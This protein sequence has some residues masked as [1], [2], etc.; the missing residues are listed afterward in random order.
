[1]DIYFKAVTNELIK[2]IEAFFKLR[3][4]ADRTITYIKRIRSSEP[5]RRVRSNGKNVIGTYPSKKMGLSIQFE[6]KTLELPAIFEKEHSRSVLEY[7]DQPPSFK[8]SYRIK[9]KN[10][11]HLYTAD[12]FVISDDWIGWEEW[13]TEDEII[14]LSIDYPERYQLDENGIWRCP[15]AEKHAGNYGLSFKVKI[16][17]DLNMNYVRNIKFLEDYLLK[18]NLS[19]AKEDKEYICNLI[20]ENP[21]ITIREFLE[22][23]V[24]LQVDNL[25]ISFILGN[26]YMDIENE[27]IPELSA[28]LYIS[29]EYKKALSNIILSTSIPSSKIN[30]F[31]KIN[32]GEKIIWDGVTWIILNVGNTSIILINDEK[33]TIDVPVATFEYLLKEGKIKGISKE[34]YDDEELEIIKKASPLELVKANEKFGLLEPYLNGGGYKGNEPVTERTIQNWMRKYREAERK[35]GYGYVGLLSQEYKK[36]NRNKRISDGVQLLME[37]HIREKYENIKQSNMKKVYLQFCQACID[38]GYDPPSYYT[39]TKNVKKTPCYDRVKK[40]KGRKAAYAIG[41]FIYELRS[42]TPRHGDRIFEICHLDHTELDIE[43]RC[44]VTGKN[45]GRPWATFLVDA[46]SRRLLAI[47]ISYDPPSYRSCM[48]VLRECVKRYSR[49]PSAIV[50]DGGKEFESV[51]FETL[52]TRNRCVKFRRPGAK[53]RFGNVVERLFGTTNEMFINNLTGNT[54]IMK[55]VRQVVKEIN[56]KT[57]SIWN[58]EDFV[59]LLNNWAYEI[60]DQTEHTGLGVSPRDMYERSIKTSGA[61]EVTRV[62]YDETFKILTLPTTKKGEAKVVPG[63]GVKINRIYYWAS[64]FRNGLLENR[65]VFVRYDPFN[66]GIAYAFINNKWVELQSEKFNLFKN[67]S[68][69]EVNIAFEELKRRAML[70]EKK[71]SVTIKMLSDFLNSIE[72]EELLL[73]QQLK[74]R[75]MRNLYVIEG[76]KVN[77]EKFEHEPKIEEMTEKENIR[78][79]V[80]NQGEESCQRY[81]NDIDTLKIEFESYEG[82]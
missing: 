78:L 64:V 4:L 42:E 22:K 38:E 26:F 51:Y 68:E 2:D 28:R 3:G 1:M 67:R 74:D 31:F 36:G 77:S 23:S 48:M 41:E 43:L 58:L 34:D 33:E 14:K 62:I 9:E 20:S 79:V 45:L 6:S 76:G 63:Y 66:M 37:T 72:S 18:G 69:K 82:L 15:P 80:N 17:K 52:L 46:F 8:I 44:S 75:A 39:F 13:K 53:A 30:V 60:Y 71:Q 35:Y 47:Y 49:F 11:A 16:S 12:F 7:Y 5:A 29:Q 54:Q 21:G 10:R 73:A 27:S 24:N 61:R 56:P 57:N 70:S 32:S 59:R 25:Y 50:V 65:Q 81:K 40:R 55:N 19:V